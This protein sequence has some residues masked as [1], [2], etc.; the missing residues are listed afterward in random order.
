ML[1]PLAFCTRV[2][3]VQGMQPH[4]PSVVSDD[5]PGCDPRFDES[6]ITDA[7]INSGYW[8]GIH[9]NSAPNPAEDHPP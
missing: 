9:H 1:P 3:D 5:S 4:W 8:H 7:R 2:A 6:G